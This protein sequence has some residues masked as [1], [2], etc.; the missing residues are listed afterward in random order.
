MVIV[1]H[2][3]LSKTVEIAERFAEDLNLYAG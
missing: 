2:P 3:E 1:R